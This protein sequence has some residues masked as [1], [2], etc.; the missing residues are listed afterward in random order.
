M[1]AGVVLHHQGIHDVVIVDSAHA[2]ENSSR[3]LII[4]AAT[5]EALNHVVY[6][7]KL[8][9]AI[10]RVGLHNGTSYRMSI[11]YSVLAPYTKFPFGLIIPQSSTEAGMLEMLGEPRIKVMRP[12]KVSLKFLQ[13]AD[14]YIG[15]VFESGGIVQAKYFIGADGATSVHETGIAFKDPNGDEEHDYG[16]L[17]QMAM[18]DV[19][20]STTPLL[21]T[22][23][24]RM[25]ITTVDQNFWMIT[26]F[27]EKDYPDKNGI[28]HRFVCGVY[29]EDGRAPH[30]LSCE[31]L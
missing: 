12:F 28:V 15:V 3:A 2:G 21:P 22:P 9:N 10:E 4:Q 20:F 23:A 8:L 1:P 27:L 13:D 18:G 14:H 31:Y 29:V 25:L 19:T 24:P 26:Q 30:R 6:L 16:N 7:D 5:V 17:S 11:N